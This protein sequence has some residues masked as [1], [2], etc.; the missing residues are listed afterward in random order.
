MVADTPY[1][2]LNVEGFVY[3][4]DLTGNVFY[5]VVRDNRP[6]MLSLFLEDPYAHE[7]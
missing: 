5:D 7:I 4:F 2:Y 1:E 6:F 3:N